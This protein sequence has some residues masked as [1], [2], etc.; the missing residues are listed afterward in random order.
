MSTQ[1]VNQSRGPA[2]QRWSEALATWAIPEEILAA[3]PQSP[4][5]FDVVAMPQVEP[6][7]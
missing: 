5:G 3:A 2:A 1:A 7:P 6:G 4:Y